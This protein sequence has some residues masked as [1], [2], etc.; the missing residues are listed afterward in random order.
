ML[1]SLLATISSFVKLRVICFALLIPNKWE[2]H[3]EH[4]QTIKRL[5]HIIVQRLRATCRIS[6]LYKCMNYYYYYYLRHIRTTNLRHKTQTR[7]C[8]FLSVSLFFVSLG[9]SSVVANWQS[10]FCL[11]FKIT[12]VSDFLSMEQY[13]LAQVLSSNLISE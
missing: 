13:K 6:A 11:L 12:N 9:K 7:F 5:L 10:D 2:F 1:R 8:N 4:V 3:K